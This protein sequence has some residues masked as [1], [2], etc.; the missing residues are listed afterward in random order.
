[1]EIVCSWKAVKILCRWKRVRW[2]WNSAALQLFHPGSP[3]SGAPQKIALDMLQFTFRYALTLLI[4][5]CTNVGQGK[6]WSSASIN[7]FVSTKMMQV[8][9]DMCC[10]KYCIW[11][12]C[13][14]WED[15]TSG[16]CLEKRLIK[17]IKTHKFKKYKYT[18]A[19]YDKCQ[20]DPKCH[21]FLK[22]VLF[23]EIKIIFPTLHVTSCM[24][25]SYSCTVIQCLV[26][27]SLYWF[28]L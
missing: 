2:K 27:M 7:N 26:F 16:I 9:S 3:V 12:I 1:M 11:Q 17:D 20:R 28:V 21:I 15:P 6:L 25:P 10:C 4:D 22:T 5:S 14:V 24:I 23:K 19:A 18:N 13:K 8:R